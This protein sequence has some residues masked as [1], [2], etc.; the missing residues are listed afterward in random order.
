MYS[1]PASDIFTLLFMIVCFIL[2]VSFC[3]GS[4]NSSSGSPKTKSS[5][6]VQTRNTYYGNSNRECPTCGA[7]H[8]DGYCEECGYPDINQGWLGENF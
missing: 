7:P 3:C 4:D 1:N 5:K 2:I 6:T 8:Y